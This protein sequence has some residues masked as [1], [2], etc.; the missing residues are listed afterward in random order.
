MSNGSRRS[1]C[2][3]AWLPRRLSTNFNR[4]TAVY[5]ARRFCLIAKSIGPYYGWPCVDFGYTHE[6]RARRPKRAGGALPGIQMLRRMP[7]R[8]FQTFGKYESARRDS[9]AGNDDGSVLQFALS[10][11]LQE[12]RSIANP[13]IAVAVIAFR[14]EM[15]DRMENP[16]RNAS[17]VVTFARNV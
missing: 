12:S 6:L 16:P 10:C 8:Y 17:V 9:T 1:A 11:E 4:N 5:V 2:N 3:L 14:R 13:R 15:Q 7:R